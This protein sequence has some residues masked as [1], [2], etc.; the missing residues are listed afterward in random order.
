MNHIV[1]KFLGLYI[2]LLLL[3]PVSILVS[4]PKI[5]VGELR[6]R[7][8][9]EDNKMT[10]WPVRAELKTDQLFDVELRLSGN[11]KPPYVDFVLT[12]DPN[13]ITILSNGPVPGNIYSIYQARFVDNEKG[14]VG[15][16]GRGELRNGVLFETLK[17]MTKKPGNPN[18][19]V[20]YLNSGENKVVVELPRYIVR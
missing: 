3:I 12:F 14:L 9:S 4:T 13:I 16:G 1:K 2:L 20:S 17:I 6:S 19:K 18:F 11:P 5:R 7:A 10:F 8:S 15:I